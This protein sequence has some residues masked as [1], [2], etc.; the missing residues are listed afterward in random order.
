MKGIINQ[1]V[2]RRLKEELP[3]IERTQNLK[4]MFDL[5]WHKTANFR[6]AE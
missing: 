4:E 5:E 3:E 2:S 1:E 6:G